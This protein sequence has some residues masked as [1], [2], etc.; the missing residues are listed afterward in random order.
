MNYEAIA[1]EAGWKTSDFGFY[2]WRH[3]EPNHST[4]QGRCP[5]CEG[6]HSYAEC[7][8]DP[9]SPRVLFIGF[10]EGGWKAAC[11]HDHLI[12]STKGE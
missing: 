12:P 7:Q 6:E 2:V 1:R 4:E 11:E 9:R 10:D 5:L 8:A 3:H